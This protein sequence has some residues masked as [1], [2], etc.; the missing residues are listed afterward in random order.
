MKR[1]IL[2]LAAA[3][4]LAGCEPYN[5]ISVKYSWLAANNT[6]ISV[7]GEYEFVDF[8]KEVTPEGVTVT[9][10]YKTRK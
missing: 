5:E 1:L 7:G 10:N 4:L 3:L 6:H 9:I 8:K 2:V